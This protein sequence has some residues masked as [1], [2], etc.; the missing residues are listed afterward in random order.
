[1]ILVA[2]G[3]TDDRAFVVRGPLTPIS[4]WSFLVME[5]LSELQPEDMLF[6]AQAHVV[7]GGNRWLRVT[8][9]VVCRDANGQIRW[10]ED[11]ITMIQIP[12]GREVPAFHCEEVKS[13]V[14]PRE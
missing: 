9:H 13:E 7:P 4:S 10:E 2:G 12:A 3:E 1:M 5:I 11:A 6:R 14:L 8:A